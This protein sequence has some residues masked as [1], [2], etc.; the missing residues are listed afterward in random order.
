[1]ELVLFDRQ[2]K[3]LRS[4]QDNS[5]L[6]PKKELRHYGE[7]P[8]TLAIMM[9]KRFGKDWAVDKKLLIHFFNHFRVGRVSLGG[10]RG[11]HVPNSARSDM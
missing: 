11:I 7:V 8:Q 6:S 2:M 4:E 5:G 9:A 3:R 1:M 10:G